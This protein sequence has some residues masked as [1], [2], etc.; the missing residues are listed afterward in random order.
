MSKEQIPVFKK[1]KDDN[2]LDSVQLPPQENGISF[3]PSK[4][5]G[6]ERARLMFQKVDDDHPQYPST[7]STAKED[8]FKR[9][10]NI[11]SQVLIPGL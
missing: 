11:N 10:P 9:P 3:N 5:F 1:K 4:T 8:M 6:G 7:N 2:L